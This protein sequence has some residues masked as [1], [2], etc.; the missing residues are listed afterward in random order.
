M[1]TSMRVVITGAGG[2]IPRAIVAAALKHG[3]QVLAID[4]AFDPSLTAGWS[5]FGDQIRWIEGSTEALPSEHYDAIVHGA[6]IT[7]SPEERGESPE[8][9]LRANVLPT[10]NVLEWASRYAGRAI[11]MSSSGIF[12]ATHGPVSEDERPTPAGTYAVAK[13]FTEAY[14]TTLKEQ[15][16]R[17][18]ACI[19]LS[20]IYGP[21]EQPRA[22]RPRISLVGRYIQQALTTGKIDVALPGETRDWTFAPDVAEVIT[23]MICGPL[24]PHAL[25]NVAAAQVVTNLQI[26][27]AVQA[28]LPAIDIQAHDQAQADVPPLTRRG[29]LTNDRLRADYGFDAWTPLDAGI[30]Q[31]IEQ[32]QFFLTGAQH[33]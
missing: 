11:V 2:F 23:Q 15:Y 5:A 13:A 25:Y 9:N 19:R 7:A 22:S 26:A 16:G 6:A 24:P 14:I 27:S 33:S 8:E 20:N 3:M 21:E 17:D 32:M 1:T 30:R 28:A 10:L 12:R 18:V 29:W 4:L 31:C